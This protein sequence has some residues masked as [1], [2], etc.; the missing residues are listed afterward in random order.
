[1]AD[2]GILYVTSSM[3]VI[4]LHMGFWMEKKKK[5]KEKGFKKGVVCIWMKWTDDWVINKSYMIL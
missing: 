5:K 1:M 2:M 4:Q 3:H